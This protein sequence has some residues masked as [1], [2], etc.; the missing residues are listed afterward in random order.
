MIELRYSPPNEL[1][2]MGTVPELGDV[3]SAVLEAAQSTAAHVELNADASI[4]PSPYDAMLSRLVVETG[5]GPT[6]VSVTNDAIHIVGSPS[7][8]ETL[9]SFLNFKPDAQRGDHTHYEYYEGNQWIAP[10]SVPLVF[11]VR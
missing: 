7:C 8:L 10:D 9:A 5:T 4:D 2:I 11:S 3:R 1:D 6:K